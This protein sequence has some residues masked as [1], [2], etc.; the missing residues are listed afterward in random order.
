[1]MSGLS[2]QLRRG[3]AVALLLGLVGAAIGL[4]VLLPYFQ[5]RH[6]LDYMDDA[7]FRLERFQRV[8]AEVGPLRREVESLQ[9]AWGK[10]GYL[11]PE[12]TP[13][14]AATYLQQRVTETVQEYGGV[15]RRSQVQ[16]V[17]DEQGFQ[18]IG[19][20]V[21]F[22]GSSEVLRGVLYELERGQ[23]LLHVEELQVSVLRS[24]R[25]RRVR[26]A[27]NAPPEPRV[28]GGDELNVQLEL[29]G[30]LQGENP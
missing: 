10:M 30:Y 17:V 21:N 7:R 6:Y 3:L 29:V 28:E 2:P 8:A 1:M 16:P 23:P 27:R 26:R 13:T 11:L 15:L 25:S 24:V 9:E 12:R 22:S 19:V 14:L 18:R 20:Q 4:F 5:Y